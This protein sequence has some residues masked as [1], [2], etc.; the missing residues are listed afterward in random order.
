MTEFETL[1]LKMRET[2][3]LY[4]KTRDGSILKE[5]KTLE[6]SVDAMLAQLVPK[7]PV[8]IE[9]QIGMFDL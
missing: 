8:L 1:V 2:Q 4:F 9:N 3:K 6:R 5:S 7:E